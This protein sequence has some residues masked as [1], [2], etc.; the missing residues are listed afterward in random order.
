MVDDVLE[1]SFID[2]SIRGR[3]SHAALTPT[4]AR[5]PPRAIPKRKSLSSDC[6]P[7]AG[8]SEPEALA[9]CSA[10]IR[11]IVVS[12]ANEGNRRE[13]RQSRIPGEQILPHGCFFFGPNS[14]P[15]S[16]R[17]PRIESWRVWGDDPAPLRQPVRAK[18]V[19]NR[20]P[21]HCSS[22]AISVSPCHRLIA[23]E[24]RDSTERRANPS[25]SGSIP[26]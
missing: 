10:A 14:A 24:R 3:A 1:R 22:P 11:G 21:I 23:S 19:T 17:I 4:P 15:S 5:T 20:N 12:L 13:Q 6:P 25:L 2:S 9:E 7:V 26:V 16:G 8:R 18:R